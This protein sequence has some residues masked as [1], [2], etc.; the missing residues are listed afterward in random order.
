M[1]IPRNIFQILFLKDSFQIPY[2]PFLNLVCNFKKKRHRER[3]KKREMCF[4]H[5]SD[6]IQLSFSYWKFIPELN[7]SR[8]D[9][10][11]MQIDTQF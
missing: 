10:F 9:I 1:G 2:L 4:K 11:E 3:K 8:D 6:V 7:T 5:V